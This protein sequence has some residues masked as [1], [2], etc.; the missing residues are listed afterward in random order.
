MHA[1]HP[2]SVQVGI[3]EL[4]SRRTEPAWYPGAGKGSWGGPKREAKKL[5]L[6]PM[7]ANRQ[8]FN[9]LHDP[10]RVKHLRQALAEQNFMLSARISR[11]ELIETG[12][13]LKISEWDVANR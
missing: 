2:Y 4:L 5:S 3:T 9:H 1:R 13:N 7:R 11:I 6:V 12:S 10:L 8:E